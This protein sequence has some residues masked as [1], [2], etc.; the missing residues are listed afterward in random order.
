MSLQ[1][2]DRLA[3]AT[4]TESIRYAAELLRQRLDG[5][6]SR[7]AVVAAAI[8]SSNFCTILATTI[9][10]APLQLNRSNIQRTLPVWHGNQGRWPP[11]GMLQQQQPLLI[12]SDDFQVNRRQP[13]FGYP[14]R[15]SV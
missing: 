12:N 14:K 13:S 2:I 15:N 6:A 3:A 1:T 5:V 11:Y 4:P 8:W 9:R 7:A 10:S